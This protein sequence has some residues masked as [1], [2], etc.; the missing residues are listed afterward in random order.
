MFSW[1][2]LGHGTFVEDLGGWAVRSTPEAITADKD[3]PSQP[4]RSLTL[5][6]EQLRPLAFS[7]TPEYSAAPAQSH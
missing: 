4:R 3:I 6:Q 5:V 1:V 7:R 2:E